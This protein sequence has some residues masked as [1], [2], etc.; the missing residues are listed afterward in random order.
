MTPTLAV[1]S[2]LLLLS[3]A[4]AAD[5]SPA[6]RNNSGKTTPLSFEQVGDTGVSA[7]MM[8]LGNNK[9]V[10]ILDKSENNP[11]TIN[12]KYGT[13]PAWAVEYDIATN[14]YRAM[15]VYSNS[16]CAGG[17]VLGNGTWAVFGGNQPVT[18]DGVAT[19]EAAAYSDT[20]GGSAI[21]MLDPCTDEQCNYV[22]GETSFDR[23]TDMGGW[24]QMTGHRW[25]PTI[26][27]LEDGTLIVIGGDK[28][29]GYVN[30]AGQDNPTYEFFPPREGDPVNLQFLTDTL[31]INLYAITWLLPSGKLFM[32]ANRKTILYDYQNKQTTNL[33]DMPYAA[34]VY[35]ASA[36]T[37]MLPLTPANNYTVTLLF[38]GG[39]NTT[40]WGNDG[41]A[42]YNVTAV[43]ADQTCVRINPDDADP[44]YEDDDAMPEG[45]S[46]GQFVLLPDGSMWM[47]NGVAMGTAG[48]GDDKYSIGQSYGQSPIYMPAVYNYLAPQGSRWNRTGLSASSNERMYHSTAVLLPDS[49]IL[50]AG[51]NP[52][53]DF[54]NDQWRSRTDSEKWYPW[55]YNEERPQYDG[56]PKSL[57]YGGDSFNLTMAGTDQTKAQNTKVVV[58]RGG[59]NTHAMGFGQKFI[60][61]QTSY[62]VDLNSGNTT[63]HVSQL[64]GNPGPTLFQP[65]PAMLFVVVNGVPSIGE[66]VMIGNGKLGKQPTTTNP[67]LPSSTIL[68]VTSASASASSTH[69]SSHSHSGASIRV[70][71]SLG[72]ALAGSLLALLV[73]A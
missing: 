23:T 17:G 5:T 11:V 35:P 60:E 66:F 50:I 7:Q 19:T 73:V 31:P 49:S 61:L 26:E 44:Q 39:S 47:G 3:S 54:T 71:V 1:L 45:R 27:T 57:S 64:P 62:T 25:Y 18:T 40:K 58:I 34:R 16:F 12:G 10:Y 14:K 28:N 9:K 69:G 38:C 36:A 51:S 37:V 15:D 2:A 53:R 20:D 41:S 55:F 46:M 33:P 22:Q 29:G 21:R 42:G 72:S 30:T 56:L 43:P 52:N 48:Y 32:Q 13:H 59:F 4:S 65:G 6:R 63:V 24:L 8:F 68:A 70:V 67:S